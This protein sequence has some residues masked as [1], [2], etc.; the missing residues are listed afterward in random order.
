L[1]TADKIYFL[2]VIL[3]VSILINLLLLGDFIF[4]KWY[5]KPRKIANIDWW[6]EQRKALQQN[7]PIDTGAVIFLGNS[8]I[9]RYPI[10]E[11]FGSPRL[12]NR[13]I[14][15]DLT[16]GLL[17]RVNDVVKQMPSALFIEGG[18]NDFENDLSPQN[19]LNNFKTL[20]QR[21]K[22]KLPN[23]KIYVLAVMPV[24]RYVADIQLYNQMLQ[25]YC[26]TNQLVWIDTY[27]PFLLQKTTETHANEALTTDGLHLNDKGYR[28]LTNLLQPFVQQSLLLHY[29]Q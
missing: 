1:K 20:V 27:S 10:Q 28:L 18:I 24:Q 19:T 8:I 14:S 5:I 2:K 23:C 6:H 17:D 11:M 25:K 7:L 13:G 16:L 3:W 21:I 12:K 22:H 9:E 4:Q 15:G 26:T 29:K